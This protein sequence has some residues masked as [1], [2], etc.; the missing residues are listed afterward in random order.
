M[1]W[2]HSSAFSSI[3]AL[4]MVRGLKF[5]SQCSRVSIVILRFFRST[6]LQ[7]L[8]IFKLLKWAKEQ[9]KGW[10]KPLSKLKKKAQL[11]CTCDS[12]LDLLKQNA[13]YDQGFSQLHY[14]LM[15]SSTWF[16]L[17]SKKAELTLQPFDRTDLFLKLRK[18]PKP[19][20]TSLP[21]IHLAHP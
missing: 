12:W 16:F 19:S 21:G 6:R 20:E 17:R 3:T 9:H 8:N 4:R 2:I 11:P 15:A 14:H 7:L 1:C 18:K 5:T 13:N 10:F